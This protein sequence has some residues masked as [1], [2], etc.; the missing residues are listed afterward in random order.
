MIDNREKG[1]GPALH[2]TQ[3]ILRRTALSG[4]GQPPPRLLQEANQLMMP[5][6]VRPNQD[7]QYAVR[8]VH[9]RLSNQGILNSQPLL[10]TPPLTRPQ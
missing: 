10:R 3:P 4:S 5:E 7:D 6:Q 1:A 8:Q 2:G 9:S